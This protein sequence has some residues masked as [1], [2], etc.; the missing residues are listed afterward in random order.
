MLQPTRSQGLAL[1]SAL[2]P[3]RRP[4]LDLIQHLPPINE[5]LCLTPQNRAPDICTGKPFLS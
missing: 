1:A 5:R 2:H 3:A 4:G